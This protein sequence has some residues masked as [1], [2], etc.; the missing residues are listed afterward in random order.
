MHMFFQRN[1]NDYSKQTGS[2]LII[3]II[4]LTILGILGIVAL[5]VADLN[6]FMA[7]ND[8]DTKESFFHADSGTNIGHEFL[9]EAHFE[10]N[11]TFYASDANIWQNA[12]NNS[13]C[14][15]SPET[16]TWGD[17][18]S[19]TSPEILSFFT[20]SKIGTY[21]RAGWLG[22]GLLEGSA[23]Q[24]GAGY[25][26]IGKSVA[27]GGTYTDYL[28]RSRRYGSRSSFSEVD[29]GWRHVDN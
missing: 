7:A 15:D 20:G 28:I 19:C 10:G 27:H 12:V 29:L 13:T 25:E 23:M 24:I 9:E 8:R 3:A 6:I 4:V 21:V 17:C 14:P 16:P 18:L 26:G 22:N 11:S 5:D 2:A 1:F